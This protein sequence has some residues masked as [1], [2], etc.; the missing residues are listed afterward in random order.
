MHPLRRTAG[1][2]NPSPGLRPPSPPRGEGQGHVTLSTGRARDEGTG[3]EVAVEQFVE[4][5]S[6]A[7]IGNREPGTGKQEQAAALPAAQA[8]QPSFPAAI[9]KPTTNSA[10]SARTVR[11]AITVPIMPKTLRPSRKRPR[12]L[13]MSARGGKTKNA[14]PPRAWTGEP[15]PGC[16]TATVPIIS[17]GTIAKTRPILPKI[18]C[19][20]LGCAACAA[21]SPTGPI[22]PAAMEPLLC[23]S[24]NRDA[25]SQMIPAAGGKNNSHDKYYIAT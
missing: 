12:T 10:A 24:D 8:A 23:R 16:Q 21:A 6:T 18:V 25:T 19:L 9:K 15:Q 14:S 7:L 3:A 1:L 22:S 5:F 17:Q 4:R 13:R 20:A 11:P 2:S